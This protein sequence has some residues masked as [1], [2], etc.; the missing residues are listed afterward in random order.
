MAE[1]KEEKG[2]KK[3]K[4]LLLGVAALGISGGIVTSANVPLAPVRAEEAAEAEE[5]T[6]KKTFGDWAKE[7]YESYIVPAVASVSITSV[8]SMAISIAFAILNRSTN[9]K[10]KLSNEETIALAIKTMSVATELINTM[11]AEQKL[12]EETKKAL[13]LKSK[14]V[15]DKIAEMIDKTEKMAEMKEV[16]ILLSGMIVELS[17]ADKK[18]VSSGVASKIAELDNQLKKI[19]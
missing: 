4:F 12:S 11:N 14:E 17:Q 19:A 3:I 10:I 13:M 18:A 15:L 1:I 8:L 2:M 7:K 9:K 6:E 16:L 5:E